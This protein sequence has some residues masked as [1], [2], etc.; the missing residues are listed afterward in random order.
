MKIV[1]LG[2]SG[3]LGSAVGK[4][5]LNAYGE[6]N[7]WLSVRDPKLAYSSHN[8]L[9]ELPLKEHTLCKIPLD[10]DYVINCIGII[11]P[12]VEKVGIANTI[13]IN[14]VFPHQLEAYCEEHNIRLI[15][16]TTDCVYS[17]KDDNY[18]EDDPHDC[19]DI[20]GRSKCLGEPEDWAMTLRTSIIGEELHN[21]ASLVE[22]AKSQK[23]KKVTGF[24]NHYWNG[25]TT[26]TYA[27]ICQKI[28]DQNIMYTPGLFHVFSPTRVNKYELLKMISN[29]FDLSLD[30]EP[31]EF[32]WKVDRTLSSN[33]DLSKDL[34]IP[35]ISEQILEM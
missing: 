35:P 9:F 32:G 24:T 10:A 15:H 6:E 26:A 21:N 16:I 22:W 14:S 28:I 19:N 27:R 8:I 20:Y 12:F 2:A 25:I 11:K 30:I 29:R 34:R 5:M 23:G 4:Y 31:K 17:G 18:T 7:V 1:V 13:L 3:M 33:S